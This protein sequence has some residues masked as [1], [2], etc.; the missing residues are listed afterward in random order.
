MDEFEIEAV[1]LDEIKE[2][3]IG[4]DTEDTGVYVHECSTWIAI[5]KGVCFFQ[6]TNV[7]SI[8]IDRPTFNTKT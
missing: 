1:S 6:K 8:N 5:M 7:N 2:V 4:H 3:K